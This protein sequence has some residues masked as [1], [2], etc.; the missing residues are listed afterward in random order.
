MTDESFTLGFA[1]LVNAFVLTGHKVEPESRDIYFKLLSRIPDALWERA[2][3]RCL[4]DCK[5]FPTIKEIGEAAVGAKNLLVEPPQEYNPWAGKRAPAAPLR[6][7]WEEALDGLVRAQQALAETPKLKAPEGSKDERI[8][9]LRADNR[10]LAAENIDLRNDLRS[11][12]FRCTKA[13]ERLAATARK[14]SID[15]RREIL[16]AQVKQL[17]S[18]IQPAFTGERE[19]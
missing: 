7:T 9:I 12:L 11:L 16:K 6:L 8:E 5:F 10:R 19:L 2:I 17:A 4:V 3:K 1:A 13:E 18:E 14:R 15:E